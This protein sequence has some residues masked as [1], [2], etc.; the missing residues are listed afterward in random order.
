M[1]KLLGVLLAFFMCCVPIGIQAKE[2]VLS[3]EYTGQ[4]IEVK[5]AIWYLNEDNEFIFGVPIDCGKYRAIYSDYSYVDYEITPKVVHVNVRYNKDWRQGYQEED[6]YLCEYDGDYEFKLDSYVNGDFKAIDY[7]DNYE[8]EFEPKNKKDVEIV[9]T[10][11]T[12]PD[13]EYVYTGSDI[14]IDSKVDSISPILLKN[15]GEYIVSFSVDSNYYE[16]IPFKV[17]ILPKTVQLRLNK[18]QKYVGEKDPVLETDDYILTR[19]V[20]EGVGNYKFTAKSK[21]RNYKYE[22][23]EN[24]MFTILENKTQQLKP[25]VTNQPSN[26]EKKEPLQSVNASNK[27]KNKYAEASDKNTNII[28]ETKVDKESTKTETKVV[29]GVLNFT[30]MYYLMMVSCIAVIIYILII[31]EMLKVK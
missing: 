13:V 8:F 18:Y 4:K 28:T 20:G 10:T 9:K 23:I 26:D 12:H 2:E 15:A 17:T 14:V 19:E 5:G 7:N 21:S 6:R 27:D 24:D 16:S 1:K 29:T 11:I 30:S 22:I 25:E 31:K 3:F